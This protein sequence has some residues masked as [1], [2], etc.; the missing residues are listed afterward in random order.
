MEVGAE[1]RDGANDLDDSGTAFM[2]QLSGKWLW[3][4][5]SECLQ[6]TVFLFLSAAS[7]LCWNCQSSE[8]YEHWS[9]INIS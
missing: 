6:K 4:F 1:R 3:A 5:L 9:V 2:Q 8:T 7:F